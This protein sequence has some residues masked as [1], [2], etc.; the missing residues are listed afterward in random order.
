MMAP[1]DQGA[2]SQEVINLKEGH[3]DLK[4]DLRT[5]DGRMESGFSLVMQ[6]L[7]T[8]GKVD[9][10]PISVVVSALLSVGAALYYPVREAISE[11]KMALDIM[12]KENEARVIRLWDAENQTARD[13][14]Y[15]KGQLHPL[16]P[17]R[18]PGDESE[19][20]RAE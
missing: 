1:L 18:H 14:A 2:L 3:A 6:K 16:P 15:L 17:R 13:E 8:K 20:D 12:R 19:H 9:W 10:T 7:D 4:R 5:L 11:N